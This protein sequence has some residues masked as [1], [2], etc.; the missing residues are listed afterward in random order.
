VAGLKGQSAAVQ[1]YKTKKIWN[2]PD[3]IGD[4]QAAKKNQG[5]SRKNNAQETDAF[6]DKKQEALGIGPRWAVVESYHG[7]SLSTISI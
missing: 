1:T 2:Y 6:L 7:K 4:G 3:V 5:A